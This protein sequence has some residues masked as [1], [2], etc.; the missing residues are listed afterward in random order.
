[1]PASLY[2]K[3]S[4]TLHQVIFKLFQRDDDPVELWTIHVSIHVVWFC[5]Y[6]DMAVPG[7]CFISY[8]VNH[9]MVWPLWFLSF[10]SPDL[11]QL[12]QQIYRIRI[13]TIAVYRSVR[14]CNFFALLIWAWSVSKYWTYWN[15]FC[16]IK[17]QVWGVNVSKRFKFFVVRKI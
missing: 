4:D 15:C 9:C 11:M 2:D 10:Q 8:T 16:K 14:I 12:I 17:I 6:P 13:I 3:F 7:F 5:H 1:M